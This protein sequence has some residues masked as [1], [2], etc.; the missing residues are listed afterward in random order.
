MKRFIQGEHRGQST[1]LP[2]SLEDYVYDSSQCAWGSTSPPLKAI[3]RLWAF[4]PEQR[5]SIASWKYGLGQEPSIIA[6]T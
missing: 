6:S 3:K 2:Q 1:L 5:L 4:D